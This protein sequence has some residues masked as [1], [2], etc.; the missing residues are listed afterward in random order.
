MS[1]VQD[2]DGTFGIL[3]SLS[4]KSSPHRGHT[5]LD[6]RINEVFLKIGHGEIDGG[7]GMNDI[8][9]GR[10]C[11]FEHM[12]ESVLRNNIRHRDE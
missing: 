4:G 3:A 10:L 11:I 6:S 8:V 12:I 5:P 9:K 2:A 1:A 7:S